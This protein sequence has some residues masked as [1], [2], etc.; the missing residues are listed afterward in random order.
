MRLRRLL[1]LVAVSVVIAGTVFCIV[2]REEVA[3]MWRFEKHQMAINRTGRL[4]RQL[5]P[6]LAAG[7]VEAVRLLRTLLSD[8]RY[9][10]GLLDAALRKYFRGAEAVPEGELKDWLDRHAADLVFD[11]SL[12]VFCVPQEAGAPSPTTQEIQAHESTTE[13]SG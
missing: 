3:G 4:V 5:D 1:G 12:R 8:S 13:P 2:A 7:D 11:P 6:K 10:V 9:Q